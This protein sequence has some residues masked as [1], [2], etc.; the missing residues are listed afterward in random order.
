MTRSRKDPAVADYVPSFALTFTDDEIQAVQNDVVTILASGRL[1]LGP[2]TERF[3]EATA[4]MAGTRHAVASNSGTSAL[5]III[6][7][8]A[9]TGRTVLVPSNTNYATAVAVAN[10]GCRVALYDNGLYPSLADVHDKISAA[11]AVIVVHIGGH[12][13]T[14]L[15]ALVTLC[16]DRGIPLIEDAAHAHGGSLNGRPAG[17]WG[18][19]AAFSF[20]PT[21]VVTSGE[22]G[23]ITTDDADLAA[24]AR[25]FRDQ[26][27]AA[28]GRLHV[29]WGNSWRMTEISAAVALARYGRLAADIAGRHDILA[30]YS[31]LLEGH[32][33]L[34]VPLLGPDHRPSGYKAI[35]TLK[36]G[37]PARSFLK[38]AV[39]DRGVQLSR[40][41]YE[42]PLHRQPLFQSLAD[43]DL[44]LADGFAARH[45]CLPIWR[46]ITT[47]QAE[48]AARAV[49]DALDDHDAGGD[50]LTDGSPV[51]RPGAGSMIR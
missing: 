11:A 25:R 24:A 12:L 13:S 32:P 36:E 46:G 20:Y 15:P 40:E 16:R 35:V 42:V 21:K 5:E 6:R 38:V 19:A 10:A 41:V 37:A 3:E 31:Q 22:G 48:T 43:G 4:A 8:L 30:L 45:L 18:S 34:A 27:K 2:F 33:D 14:D 9:I 49:I 50:V 7:A 47:A 39:G 23:A 17:S 44:P 28:D 1:V 26:G 29:V 51:A